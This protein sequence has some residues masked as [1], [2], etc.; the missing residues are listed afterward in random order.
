MKRR[1][2]YKLTFFDKHGADGGLRIKAFSY[3]LMTFAL[4]VSASLLAGAPPYV[5]LILGIP[6][7]LATGFGSWY[8]GK[9][10][11][12]VAEYVTAGGSS[13]PYEEQFSQQQAL[14]MQEKYG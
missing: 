14:V 11:G 10:A 9:S 13:T 2:S 1:S 12:A 4:V 3:A 7:S 5:T 6:L 8:L